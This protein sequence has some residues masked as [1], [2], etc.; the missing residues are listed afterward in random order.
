MSTSPWR[1]GKVRQGGYAT[2]PV[3]AGAVIRGGFMVATDADGFAVE[4][5]ADDTLIVWGRAA[6]SVDNTGGSDG[7]R[8]IS[9]ELSCGQKDFLFVNGSSS[10][11]GDDVGKDC[12]VVDSQ[13]VSMTS[14]DTCVAGTVMG[15]AGATGVWIRFKH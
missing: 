5:S 1:F 14:T 8:E 11:G 9:V 13:T 10:V 3:A 2:F 7:A 6:D 4:A 12:Y 15:I